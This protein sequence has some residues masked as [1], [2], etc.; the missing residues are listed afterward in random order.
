MKGAR[1]KEP[2]HRLAAVPVTCHPVDE[3][4]AITAK[5]K[6]RI[7]TGNEGLHQ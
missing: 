6:C 1:T 2:V 5:I 7:N 3:T 4:G